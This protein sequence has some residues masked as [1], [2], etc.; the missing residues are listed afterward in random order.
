MPAFNEEESIRIAVTT[1]RNALARYTDDSEVIVVND[2]STDGTGALLDEM[3]ADGQLRALHSPENRGY[4]WALRTGF[5]AAT[6]PL[7]FLTDSDDQFDPMDLG[8]VLPL[9]DGADIVIGYRARRSE[10]AVRA[11]I[12]AGYNGLV[13]ALLDVRVRDINCAFKLVRREVL[14]C[15][16]LV[17]AGYTI[18]AEMIAQAAAAKLQ[19]R[20]APVSHRPRHAGHSKIRLADVLWSLSELWAVRSSLPHKG[21]RRTWSDQ[22]GGEVRW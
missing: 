9:I 12:S 15:L 5:A 10:G 11:V 7:I 2:G 19:V 21:L 6:R 14:M 17:S 13:R 18:N 20:E 3:A 16:P 8:Q 1:V 22:P 4:G